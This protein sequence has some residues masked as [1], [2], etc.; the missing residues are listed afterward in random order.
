MDRKIKNLLSNYKW[1]GYELLVCQKIINDHLAID[2][3]YLDSE[4]VKKQ[5]SLINSYLPRYNLLKQILIE[6]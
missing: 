3:M 5:Q 1:L 2:I 6:R 4:Q